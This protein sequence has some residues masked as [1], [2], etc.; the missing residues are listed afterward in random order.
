MHAVKMK[1][2]SL[3]YKIVRR[4]N[5]TA[6]IRSSVG[7]L[8]RYV[9]IVTKPIRPKDTPSTTK[10]WYV[11]IVTRPIKPKDTPLARQTWYVPMVAKRSDFKGMAFTT[12]K[13][14]AS[15]SRGYVPIVSKSVRL[16]ETAS[17]RVFT[18]II[19]GN[20]VTLVPLS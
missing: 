20:T 9:P 14:L 10:R 13:R 12:P 19:T 3:T 11:P 15:A 17:N 16:S 7:G 4:E 6:T 2:S 18:K 1:S 8:A 5:L